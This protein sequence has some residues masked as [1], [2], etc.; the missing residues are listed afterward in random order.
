[1][2]GILVHPIDGIQ[3]VNSEFSYKD[4]QKHVDGT[5]E[6]IPQ[7]AIKKKFREV[8][9]DNTR[10]FIYYINEEGMIRNLSDNIFMNP[11]MNHQFSPFTFGIPQGPCIILKKNNEGKTETMTKD[12][13]DLFLSKKRKRG[14]CD[15][16]EHPN[17]KK[18]KTKR[19]Y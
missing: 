13:L 15:E 3:K 2:Y 9:K 10:Q 14:K 17:T 1:M 19:G 18:T 8:C 6:C 5:F 7:D 11:F 16:L 4:I 12:E